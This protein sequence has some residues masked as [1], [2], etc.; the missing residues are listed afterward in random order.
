MKIASIHLQNFKRFTDLKIQNI[1]A[2]AKLVVLLGPNGCGKSSVFDALH[3]KS[4]EYR[5]LGRRDDPDYY[6]KIL[7]QGRRS[8][9]IDIEF[10]NS[11]QSNMGKAIYVRTAYRNDPVINVE[12]IQRLPSVIQETRFRSMIENDAAAT[13]NYQRLASNALERAFNREDREKKFRRLSRRDPWRD[14]RCYESVV[15]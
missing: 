14:S 3:E 10:H 15:S 4:Y 12:S 8:D 2:T 9:Q 7:I 1:P 6:S 11:S 5:Q 13:G